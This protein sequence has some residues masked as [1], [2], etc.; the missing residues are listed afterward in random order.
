MKS[1]IQNVKFPI[2]ES[3]LEGYYWETEGL[4][5]ELKYTKKLK[6]EVNK[7]LKKWKLPTSKF[8]F[9]ENAFTYFDQP[10]TVPKGIH[11]VADDF[12]VKEYIL[13]S[14]DKKGIQKQ[15]KTEMNKIDKEIKTVYQ[16][17]LKQY[18]MEANKARKAI[19]GKFY[20]KNSKGKPMKIEN[21]PILKRTNSEKKLSKY[22][23][24]D[25]KK[26]HAKGQVT[27]DALDKAGIA[28]FNLVMFSRKFDKAT[29]SNT[30]RKAKQLEEAFYVGTSGFSLAY[31][32]IWD[33]YRDRHSL[34]DATMYEIDKHLLDN[35]VGLKEAQRNLD[36][37]IKST[38]TLPNDEILKLLDKKA[39]SAFRK[40]Q[41][42]AKELK[43]DLTEAASKATQNSKG[44]PMKNALSDKKQIEMWETDLSFLKKGSGM[45]PAKLKYIKELEDNVKKL[46]AK[47]K[48]NSKEKT[49]KNAKTEK[50]RVKVKKHID[51]IWKKMDSINKKL[52]VVKKHEDVLASLGLVTPIHSQ[53]FE[54]HR[55]AHRALLSSDDWWTKPIENKKISRDKALKSIEKYNEA[56]AYVGSRAQEVLEEANKANALGAGI[57]SSFMSPLKKFDNITHKRFRED[58]YKKLPPRENSKNEKSNVIEF[59]ATAY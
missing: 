14:S 26:F 57:K 32:K 13:Q 8:K 39:A 59:K 15:K 16:G 34:G 43:K 19:D 9:N 28:M 58:I 41:R 38:T 42:L 11:M 37:I 49:M 31:M 21:K 51:K 6:Q 20:A 17:L 48:E 44:K 23:D 12:T 10:W 45:T 5:R 33:E 25:L 7:I 55:E 46:R 54:L 3:D 50:D 35:D 1:E 29:G 40:V 27:D 52:P 47:I 56:I 22:S 18:D 4:K 30:H 53:L 24:N 2:Y 36:K